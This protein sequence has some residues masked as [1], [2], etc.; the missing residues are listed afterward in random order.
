[1]LHVKILRC[2]L[3]VGRSDNLNLTITF[4]VAGSNTNRRLYQATCRL[5]ALGYLPVK[6]WRNWINNEAEFKRGDK[7]EE[8]DAA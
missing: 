6:P 8:Q 5:R 7:N 4:H 3:V 1:M 2:G